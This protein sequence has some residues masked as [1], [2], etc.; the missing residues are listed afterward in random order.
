MSGQRRLLALVAGLVLALLGS[1]GVQLAAAPAAR[2]S[3]GQFHG[4]NW[5]DQRDNFLWDENV[6][7]G[8]SKSDNYATTYTKATAVL[9]GF[10]GLGTN[11]VRFGINPQT[12]ASSWWGSLTAAYDAASALGMNVMIAPWTPPDGSGRING[13]SAAF[14]RMWDTVIA[15][16]GGKS[17]FY[18][19]MIN[20]PWGY[21]ATELTNL[22]ADWLAHY[23]AIPRGR[24]VIPGL[25]ADQDICTVGAD[26]RLNGTL[27]SIHLYTLGG[28]THPTAAEWAATFRSRL[29]GY[30]D[31]A[32]LSEF[33]V[34]MNTGINYNGPRDGTNNVSYLYGLTDTVRS[35]GMGS[36]LW[37]GVKQADQ[38]VGPG[39][40]FN[41]SCA[42]TSLAGS[43]TNLSLTV[44]NQSGLDRF[45]YGWGL[46]DNPGGGS[47][48]S[49]GVLR[50]AGSNRCLDVPGVSQ[51]DGTRLQIWD[52]NGG[53]NQ[54]W[55]ALSNGALQV[56]GSKCLDVPGH[57]TAS[58]TRVQI[59]TCNGGA[60]QQWRLG[61][62]GTVIGVESGLCLDVT[63]AATANA[64]PVAIATCNG[65]TNQ[66]WTRQ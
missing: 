25:W 44:T 3:T 52:C 62:D 27:L 47:G 28:E 50:G 38:T 23:P 43:G 45:R 21:G 32:V 9:K 57:A 10:Q 49:G 33:G 7:I 65:G 29:C 48:G 61:S 54:Q 42:I 18:F 14:Y 51:A 37:T 58:G 63:G 17:N 12:T 55:A 6:P 40:C 41:A 22:A 66:K 8:L 46:N 36:L 13:E 35:L 60:N 59:Y 53:T 39:P 64:T 19:D 31:R 11:T 4:V 5:A 16:Y 34:P 1:A 15:K 2:A 30:A 26:S 20:E 56:Y 24:M